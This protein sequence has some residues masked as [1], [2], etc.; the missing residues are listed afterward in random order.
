MKLDE[1]T[2]AAYLAGETPDDER[3]TVA[4]ALVQD[5]AAREVL[6]MACEALAAALQFGPVRRHLEDQ[7]ARP[8]ARPGRTASDRDAFKAPRGRA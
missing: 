7:A 1:Y 4:A 2:L 6:H 8:P 5:Q 3:A